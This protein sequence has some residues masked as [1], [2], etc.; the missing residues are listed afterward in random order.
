MRPTIPTRPANRR[1]RYAFDMRTL[2]TDL[3][4]GWRVEGWQG[5]WHD[6]RNRSWS[7]VFR[8]G[9]FLALE[10]EVEGTPVPTMPAGVSI[11]RLGE[12]DLARLAGIV[13]RRDLA[14]FALRLEHGRE[15][16]VALRNGGAVGYGW[17]SLR[18]SPKI[19]TYPLPLPGDAAYLWDL[20]VVK[21]ARAQGIGA[22]LVA[23]RVQA[24]RQRGIG[25]FWRLLSPRRPAAMATAAKLSCESTRVVGEIVH[26]K[27]WGRSSFEYRT[28]AQL[29][30]G[31]GSASFS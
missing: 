31:A 15:C 25:R 16:Y 17:I 12:A 20:F 3:V 22:A 14:Q 9:H 24:L 7:R 26:R 10:Q 8:S 28:A 11:E 5:A 18:L 19:E 4:T 21:S 1:G 29:A 2:P 6:L 23:S 27:R 13:R 30:V